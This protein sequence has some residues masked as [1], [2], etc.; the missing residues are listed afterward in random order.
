VS[1]ALR[2]QPYGTKTNFTTKGE[3]ADAAPRLGRFDAEVQKNAAHFSAALPL[4][5]GCKAVGQKSR[6]LVVRGNMLQLDLSSA[7]A[8]RHSKFLASVD[9]MR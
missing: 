7:S 5:E 6:V 9:S 2:A 1:S 8:N 3:P 4:A